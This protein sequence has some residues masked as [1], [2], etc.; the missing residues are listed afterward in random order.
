MYFILCK[1]VNEQNFKI[2]QIGLHCMRFGIGDHKAFTSVGKMY[3]LA[4]VRA[5]SRL[6]WRDSM[7]NIG[8]A[9]CNIRTKSYER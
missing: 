3:A 6:G 2:R 9:C 4:N 5:E 8:G 1:L 7:K